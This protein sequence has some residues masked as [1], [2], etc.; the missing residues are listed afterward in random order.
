MKR[1][2]WFLLLPM[3][4]A[5]G[6]PPPPPSGPPTFPVVSAANR[7]AAFKP[8]D[9]AMAT[10]QKAAAADALLPIL[11]DP[12]LGALQGEAWVKMGDLLAGFDMKYSALIAY[13]RAIEI[14]PTTA[15]A[16]VGAAMDL[17][18][19]MGDTRLIAPALSKN[20]GLPVDTNT[21]SRMAFL[22]SRKLF[23]DG[24]LG[25]AVTVLSLVDKGSPVFG[26]S[27]MLRGVILSQQGQPNNALAPF[28]T[29]G[30]L[31]A[32]SDN[33]TRFENALQINLGRAYFA[34]NNFPR[35]IEYYAKVDRGSDYWTEAMFE[36]AW[37]HF[38]LDDMNGAL[39]YLENF[40]TPF[41]A[42]FYYPEADMLRVYSTFLLCKF[43]TADEEIGGFSKKY[44]P[45]KDE[46]D[47][48]LGAM[49]PADAWTDVVDYLDGKPSKLPSMVLRPYKTE[50]RIDG[51][52]KAVKKADEELARLRNSSANPFTERASAALEARKAAIIAEEG[53]RVIATVT[54]KRDELAQMLTNVQLTRADILM[55]QTNLLEAAAATGKEPTPP[56]DQKLRKDRRIRKTLTWQFEGEYWGDELGY[57][58]YDVRPECPSSLRPAGG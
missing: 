58:R 40:D 55:Y 13:D 25:P 2:L 36:R 24:E 11:D 33:P 3:L 15:A 17:A 56:R 7:A 6:P 8:Y 38:R 53:T 31:S 32:Q 4:F 34:A 51:A 45:V 1:W 29:A 39:G 14:D 21:R 12:K 42:D 50:D 27:E 52:S 46:L 5:G 10:G 28:L 20:V 49:T 35:A 30:A 47:R 22:A 48:E 43:N 16:K 41:L 18:D 23:Q 44:A 57:Y 19:E 26:R 9:D 37:A 54:R